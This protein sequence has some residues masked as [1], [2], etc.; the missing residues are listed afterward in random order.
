MV[1]FNK[2]SSSQFPTDYLLPELIH[3]YLLLSCNSCAVWGVVVP[4]WAAVFERG[5]GPYIQIYVHVTYTETTITPTP[6]LGHRETHTLH[7][8]SMG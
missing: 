5:L 2:I 3:S 4:G 6:T 8:S 1:S 7:P